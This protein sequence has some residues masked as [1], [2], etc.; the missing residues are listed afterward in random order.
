MYEQGHK[1]YDKASK[2]LIKH[3]G[4]SLL[5]LAGVRDLRSWEAVQAEVVQPR[6]QPD[7]TIKAIVGDGEVR[8]FIFEVATDY[9]PSVADQMAE[10]MLHVLLEQKQLPRAILLVLDPT[11]AAVAGNRDYADADHV[12]R[13]RVDWQVIKLADLAADELL[14]LGDVG[15]VP[16]IVLTRTS[17]APDDLARRC[18]EEIAAR[19]PAARHEY[20]LSVTQVLL[21]IRYPYNTPDMFR[22]L[23]TK[24]MLAEVPFIKELLDAQAAEAEKA[25]QKAAALAA[26]ESCLGCTVEN[27]SIRFGE[28]PEYLLARLKQVDDLA[29]LRRLHRASATCVDLADFEQQLAGE[30]SDE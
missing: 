21:H 23:G 12:C 16:W 20:L 13:V 28:V 15:L 19:A 2:W 6:R 5:R 27:L 14:G 22:F 9:K 4:D 26:H 7:G 1:S 17:L 8:Y 29:E 18:S 30:A 11:V 24:T 3:Y 10:D 25:M